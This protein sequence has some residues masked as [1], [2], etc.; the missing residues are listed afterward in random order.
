MNKNF[1]AQQPEDYVTSIR[2]QN[3]SDLTRVLTDGD[4][5]H[6]LF[7]NTLRGAVLFG[8]LVPDHDDDIGISAQDWRLKKTEV[9][10]ELAALGFFCIRENSQMASF[11]RDGRYIDLVFFW[12][13]GPIAGYGVKRFPSK[14]LSPARLVQLGDY[15]FSVPARSKL[16]IVLNSYLA[17]ALGRIH[18]VLR[19]VRERKLAGRARRFL[20]R[21][22]VRRPRLLRGM[23]KSLTSFLGLSL[24]EYS[25]KEFLDLRLEPEESFNLWWR[26]MHLDP[27]TDGGKMATLRSIVKHFE[28]VDLEGFGREVISETDTSKVFYEPIS[29]NYRFWR[30]GNN[31]FFYPL[32]FGFRRN[33]V[34]YNR[35]NEY[36]RK[37]RGPQIYSAEYYKSLERMSGREIVKFLR[38]SPIE[39][40]NGAILGG[41]HRALAV[42]GELI[43]GSELQAVWVL[44]NKDVR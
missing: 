15:S 33:V 42:L 17:P 11:F 9:R 24:T 25:L 26:K 14:A 30:T 38:S 39:V 7:G 43:R 19:L 31:F 6:W 1:W 21:I 22:F 44:E 5:A 37:K 28:C 13:K 29:S 36:I 2:L 34:P 4:I 3:L 12:F 27:V 16:I 23:P 35:V 20:S 41:K 18:W 32:M 8:Q 10:K 40:H